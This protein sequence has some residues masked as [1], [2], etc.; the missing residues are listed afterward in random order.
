MLLNKQLQEEKRK[1]L[2]HLDLYEQLKNRH[3]RLLCHNLEILRKLRLHGMDIDDLEKR[4]TQ[5][6]K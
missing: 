6:E 3:E 2:Q 1:K 4:L 5:I